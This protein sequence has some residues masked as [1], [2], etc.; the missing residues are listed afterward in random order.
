MYGAPGDDGGAGVSNGKRDEQLL[1]D[2]K[3]ALLA[4]Y[5]K[6]N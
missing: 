4:V 6:R 5:T 2:K 1:S 3:W